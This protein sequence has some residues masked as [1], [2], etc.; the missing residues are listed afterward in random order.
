MIEIEPIRFLADLRQE[1]IK[2]SDYRMPKWKFKIADDLIVQLQPS[3]RL[4]NAGK[5]IRLFEGNAL[6]TS[7]LVTRAMFAAPS[8][9]LHGTNIGW[10]KIKFA[11]GMPAQADQGHHWTYEF[12]GG[13][14]KSNARP[15]YDSLKIR[16]PAVLSSGGFFG[17]MNAAKL[18]FPHCLI[19]GRA[20][21]D[22]ASMA[23]FI[24]PE[25][26]GTATLNVPRLI[27]GAT[28]VPAMGDG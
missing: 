17:D 8:K 24:G 1:V 18:L 5:A 26:A 21:T 22:P 7:E 19:C 15:I 6:Q 25:C 13:S 9:V 16:V 11:I 10:S 3:T 23:R 27:V 4:V 28:A 2:K 14:W 20:L 12:R